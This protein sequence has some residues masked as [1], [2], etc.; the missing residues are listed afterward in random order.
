MNASVALWAGNESGAEAKAGQVYP[1]D[2]FCVDV[3]TET[4][5]RFASTLRCGETL[6]LPRGDDVAASCGQDGCLD[7]GTITCCADTETCGNSVD[8]DCDQQVDEGCRCGSNDCSGTRA[9]RSGGDY[10][11]TDDG[12]CGMRDRIN[13]IDKNRC[14]DL[15]TKSRP[16]T[17]Q[18]SDEVLD[19]GSGKQAVLGCCRADQ[20]CG[21]KIPP[22]ECAA[23][24]DAKYFVTSDTLAVSDKS[25]AY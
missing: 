6:V 17:A 8:D 4:Q 9:T 2:D 7:L 21:L 15:Q 12:L 25:C 22:L 18:C 11:C 23:R 20:R 19:L 14:F 1:G 10:C 5:L 13:K 24:A 16:D 3:S